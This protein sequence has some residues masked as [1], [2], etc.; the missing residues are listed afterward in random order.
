[1]TLQDFLTQLTEHCG[2]DDTTDV[3]QIAEDEQFV[4]ATFNLPEEES[5]RFIGFHGEGL[6]SLQ[7][8]A[9]L[10]FE[11]QYPEKKIVI[12]IN[13]YRERRQSQLEE[14]TKNIVQRVV[15]TGRPF[16][17]QHYLPSHERFVI[18]STI[19]NLPEADEVESVSFGD[20]GARRLTIR[21]KQQ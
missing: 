4:T 13:D 3:V 2:V 11:E 5:G 7:R 18:H 19:N 8:V 15:E 20:G 17:F 10:I 6:A 12:N 14:K 21:L 1:M 16:T 9:R